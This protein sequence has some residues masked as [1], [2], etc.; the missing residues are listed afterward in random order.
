MEAKSTVVLS[1][2]G[3]HDRARKLVLREL[4][5]CSI[6]IVDLYEYRRVLLD[7][8]VNRLKW[9]IP[10]GQ[11]PYE[12]VLELPQLRSKAREFLRQMAINCSVI[13]R[14]ESFL[15]WDPFGDMLARDG[16]DYFQKLHRPVQIVDRSR[17][18]CMDD[19]RLAMFLA[20][21]GAAVGD[22][23]SPQRQ[24]A[25]IIKSLEHQTYLGSGY[26]A[27]RLLRL[28]LRTDRIYDVGPVPVTI[29]VEEAHKRISRFIDGRV[30]FHNESPVQRGIVEERTSET[31][32]GLQAAD[33]AAAIAS[34]EYELCNSKK[35]LDRAL[36]VKRIFAGVCMNGRW[37]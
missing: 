11:D 1:V 12:F 10:P 19:A 7:D 22:A 27:K 20:R 6:F 17:L 32:L 24:A 15:E 29:Q 18:E 25:A 34:R 37:I 2:L 35:S 3:D 26:I 31:E 14:L 16:P 8:I 9:A 21:V 36:A 13:G 33:I 5:A 4:E 30:D 23:L 28:A